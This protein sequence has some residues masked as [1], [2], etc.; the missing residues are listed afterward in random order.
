MTA[1][2]NS[3]D[4]ISSVSNDLE[5]GDLSVKKY[6]LAEKKKMHELIRAVFIMA[7]I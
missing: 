5:E 2:K 7:D 4:K 3:I 6:C 1:E